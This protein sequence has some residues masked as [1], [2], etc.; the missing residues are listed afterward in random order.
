MFALVEISDRPSID[1][2]SN[3]YVFPDVLEARSR[4]CDSNV[5]AHEKLKTS[6]WVMQNV[7]LLVADIMELLQNQV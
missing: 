2:N 3:K 6:N 1:P 5:V 7:E 4:V